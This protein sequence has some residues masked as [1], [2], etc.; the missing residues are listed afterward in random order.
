MKNDPTS[1]H[2]S[3][4]SEI[5][6]RPFRVRLP[7]F[8]TQEAIGLGDVVASAG[9]ALGIAP[10]GGCRERRERLNRRIVFTR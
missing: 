10:C 9:Y 4:S 3:A 6:G 8:V 1:D 7:G 2:N 5:P